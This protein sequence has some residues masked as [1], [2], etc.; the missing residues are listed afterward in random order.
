MR[1]AISTPALAF[2]PGLNSSGDDVI[3]IGP[4]RFGKMAEAWANAA[5]NQSIPFI[6]FEPVNTA[7][8]DAACEKALAQFDKQFDKNCGNWR[9]ADDRPIIL[10]GHS[11]GGLIARHIAH[12]RPERVHLALS[13]GCPHAGAPLAEQALHLSENRA[14]SRALRVCG[15]DLSKSVHVLSALTEKAAARF[16]AER[17]LAS[18]ACAY[19]ACTASGAALSI[20]LKTFAFLTK[21]VPSDGLVAVE[22]QRFGRQI[23]IYEL[24]HIAQLGLALQTRARDR[25]KARMEF[26]RLFTDVIRSPVKA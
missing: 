24:D 20:P 2:A 14:I 7:G 13:I 8:I 26:A 17:P 3:R 5:H 6:S 19:A 4:L 12:L 11:T 25:K 22:S 10:V 21:G 16:A 18:H 23:G 15:Y 1:F 9:P